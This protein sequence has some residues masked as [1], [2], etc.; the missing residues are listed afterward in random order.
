MALSNFHQKP[1]DEGTLTKLQIFELYTR[2]WRHDFILS[3]LPDL[4]S[5]TAALLYF[6]F[7]YGI[8]Q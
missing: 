1:F 3:F 6:P 4:I 8:E 7:D 2:E 5:F